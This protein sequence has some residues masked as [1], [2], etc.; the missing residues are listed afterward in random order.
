VRALG[1]NGARMN[2]RQAFSWE[3]NTETSIAVGLREI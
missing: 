1:D 2:V 3:E